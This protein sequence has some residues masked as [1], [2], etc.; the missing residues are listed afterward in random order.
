MPVF[1]INIS[2]LKVPVPT[3]EV[4]MSELTIEGH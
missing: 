4:A 2:A 1:K 3:N